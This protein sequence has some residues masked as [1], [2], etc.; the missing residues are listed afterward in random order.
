MKGIPGR[1]AVR[2]P[3]PLRD[4]WFADSLLEGAGFELS[5]PRER[6]TI[7]EPSCLLSFQHCRVPSKRPMVANR[8]A[9]S[10]PHAKP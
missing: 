9:P 4:R 8:V 1:E 10:P 2:R 5:V 7:F 3:P 6:A